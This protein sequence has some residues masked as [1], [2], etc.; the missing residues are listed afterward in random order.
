MKEHVRESLSI[1]PRA[2]E[3]ALSKLNE[4]YTMIASS[5]HESPMSQP[6]YAA[7]KLALLLFRDVVMILKK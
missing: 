6:R 1:K 7:N 2:A 3:V 4:V 5:H